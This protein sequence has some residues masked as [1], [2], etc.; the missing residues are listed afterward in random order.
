MQK[1]KL[2]SKKETITKDGK[3]KTFYRYFTY[4]MIDVIEDGENLGQQKKS[5]E[6]HFTADGSKSM[7]KI[8]GKV[9]GSDGIFA[10][11]GGDIGLP[12]QYEVKVDE[13]G[14]REYPKAWVRSVKEFKEIPYTPKESTCKPLLDEEETEPVEI[15]G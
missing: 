1:I 9:V 11:I 12:F 7:T 5:L 10:I 8:S 2:L 6:V 4:V 13:I 14:N 15:V 3:E